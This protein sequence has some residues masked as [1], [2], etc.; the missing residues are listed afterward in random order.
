M[1]QYLSSA[2]N[3]LSFFF[4]LLFFSFL[5][6]RTTW[7]RRSS[8]SRCIGGFTVTLM[9][10]FVSVVADTADTHSVTAASP[11]GVLKEKRRGDDKGE[12]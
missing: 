9:A 11:P 7:K 3:S 6:S 2:E 1:S 12:M 10:S 5:T 8:L 4:Y